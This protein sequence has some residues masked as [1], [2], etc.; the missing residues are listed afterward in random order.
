MIG[1]SYPKEFWLRLTNSALGIFLLVIVALVAVGLVLDAVR[2][3]KKRLRDV[4]TMP[5]DTSCAGI[6][7]Q[8]GGEKIV[9]ENS[10]LPD[11]AG[12]TRP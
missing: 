1:L 3:A 5:S 7:L 2:R 10:D 4:S 9:R 11:N 8:D 6:T 12:H